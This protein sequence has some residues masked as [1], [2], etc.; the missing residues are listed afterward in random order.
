MGPSTGN[1]PPL[2]ALRA[3]EAVGRLGTVRDAASELFVTQSAISH[4]LRQLEI[5]LGAKLFERRGRSLSLTAAG[6]EYFSAVAQALTLIRDRTTTL[7]KNRER[8][9]VTISTLPSLGIHWLIPRLSRFR[10]KR[11]T[12]NVHVKYSLIGDAPPNDAADFRIRYGDGQWPEYECRRLLQTSLI[13]V[14]SP[15]YLARN[16]TVQ[17]PADLRNHELIHDENLHYWQLWLEKA[18]VPELE[19]GTELILQDQHMVIAAALAGQGV[20]LCRAVL[21]Q[22]DLADGRL[23]KLFEHAIDGENGYYVCWRDDIPLSPAAKLFRTWLSEE[24]SGSEI[25]LATSDDH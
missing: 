6:R 9:T 16:G 20:A 17:E 2:H 13:A 14:C 3:F 25:V 11:P 5:T 21:V 1:L 10:K 8:D 19:L 18:N 22:P 12:V 4:Q 15:D 23:V 24:A 7:M